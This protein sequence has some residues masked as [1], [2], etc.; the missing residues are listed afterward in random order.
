MCRWPSRAM[1]RR[2]I[3]V[4]A[5]SASTP[6]PGVIEVNVHPASSWRELMATTSDAVR[7][8]APGPPGHRKIH[9]RRPSYRHRR[10]QPR[11]AR[12]RH[13]RRQP[14]AAPAR[15]AAEPDRPTGR[16]I[17]RCRICFPACS[18]ARPARRRAS[19]RRATIGCTSSRS[20]FSS[21]RASTSPKGRVAAVAGRSAAAPL[22]DR[23]HRQHASCRVLDR[24]ALFARHVRPGGSGC[25]SSAPSRCRRTR[26]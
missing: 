7:G 26:G 20:P 13:A 15:P 16:T 4:C 11:H 9:A 23:P 10:R 12:G 24:Q 1:R 6:D 17:R 25:S 19:T 18:S 3:H 5:C 8:S 21:C 22:A 2:A 14:A